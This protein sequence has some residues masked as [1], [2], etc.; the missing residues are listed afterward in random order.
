MKSTMIQ[1]GLF[2]CLALQL[3]VLPDFVAARDLEQLAI[4]N[5]H[6]PRVFF[7]RAA[8]Q[9]I[10]VR[11]YPTYASWERQFDRLQGIMGKCLDEECLGRERRNPEFFTE[12]KRRHPEQVVLLHFNGN[13]R[14]PR[15][16]TERFFP[17][18]WIYR[19]AIE[20]TKDIPAESGPTVIHVEDAREFRLRTG[21]Y[22]TSSDDI[23]LF[24]MDS[25]GR[26]DWHYCEQ[27][28]LLDVDHSANT[29]TVK[30]GCYGTTP[31]S[32]EVGKSQA[33]AHATEGPWG[34]TNNLLWFYNFTT[35]CPKDRDG[36]T[37]ADRLV[38]DLADWFGPR[39]KLAAFDGL[40]FDVMHNQTHGD[41]DG[42]GVEDDGVI[43][44]VNQYGIG[45]VDF[46][47]NLRE[48]M[49]ENFIIQGDGAL[50]PGGVRSQ[51]AFGILNGIE[52]EGWPNLNDWEM[53]DWSGGMNRHFFW[54]DN[55]RRPVFNY[56]N[57]K[58]NE[59][60][61]GQPG[62]QAEPSVPFSRHRLVFAACQFF[63]AAT[64]FSFAPANDPDGRFGVWD[65]FRL[66]V[67]NKLGWLGRP[68]GPAVRLAAQTPDLLE[69]RGRGRE[70]ESMIS[71]PV[72][73]EV[74]PE[75][76]R[77]TPKDPAAENLRFE[78]KGVKTNGGQLYL[79]VD[80][81]GDP[82]EGSFNEMAR[83][84]QVGVAGGKLL[85][86][87][88]GPPSDTGMKLRGDKKEVPIDRDRGANFQSRPR[89]IA[90]HTLPAFFVHPPY[91]AV[92]GGYTFW[93]QEAEIPADA[94]LR[95]SI[96]MG[97]LSPQR[98]DGVWFQVHVAAVTDGD[99]ASYT[100]IFEQTTNQHQWLPQVVS[101]KAYVGKRVRLKFVADCGP[102]NNATTDHAHWGDVR[103]MAHGVADDQVTEPKQIMTWVNN[104]FFQ[105]GF[106][107]D[108]IR[109]D[110]VDVSFEVEGSEAIVLRRVTAHASPDVVYRAFENG[111]VLAN[112]SREPY[113]FNLAKL[114]P[115]RTYRRI[116]GTATQDLHTNNG[117]PV[118]PTVTLGERDGLFLVDT[119]HK[120]DGR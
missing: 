38:D 71:G 20:I 76:V 6:F 99:V 105:S 11:R 88:A 3:M 117:R 77:L 31:L 63:D 53:N 51:R 22:R 113:I 60:V 101:L 70:S 106:Y 28:Q 115:G 2:A 62:I 32:F 42:D 21:R 13:A 91:Q 45:M 104:R 64:C 82:S 8:E 74:T 96:G 85:D 109:S 36:R 12:F 59:G 18:H 79:S 30:R 80:M 44:G 87:M 108:H 41:T 55:A 4:L 58:W 114:S 47:R 72:N 97:E 61:P 89:E 118:G 25:N 78:I 100:K 52:S 102:R 5:N 49:G 46:A 119:K 27:V 75:A 23:G 107:Y 16:H 10:N 95:F 112:P 24:R 66:G 73:V 116:Q 48:R 83:F 84:A 39:G 92:G 98:S 29:I 19:K 90:G 34:K 43:D 120:T 33:A 1:S 14:D 7:F 93:A 40:E 103:I 69:G 9:A 81:K 110:T 35:H 17:G 54:R 15:Y 111:V 67:E 86:L 26:H 94:E 57:H 37:C 65:E 68:E 50:G 56:V